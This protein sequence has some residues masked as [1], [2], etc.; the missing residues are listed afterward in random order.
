MGSRD[1]V[2]SQRLR[3][4]VNPQ[5]TLSFDGRVAAPTDTIGEEDVDGDGVVDADVGI[6]LGG[7]M[8]AASLLVVEALGNRVGTESR[9]SGVG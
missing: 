7:G 1:D 4:R 3:G 5:L 6:R 8:A 2:T 9:N